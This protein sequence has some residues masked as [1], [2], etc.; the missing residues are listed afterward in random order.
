MSRCLLLGPLAAALGLVAPLSAA[1][2]LPKPAQKFFGQYCT[3][4]HGPKKQAGELRLD[5][6]TRVDAGSARQWT[7]VLERL[8]QGE[9]PPAEAL[10]PSVAEAQPI[11][12][13]LTKELERVETEGG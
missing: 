2:G 11:I 12:D 13:W 8:T 9:M 6:L 1:D 3:R 7:K 10:Q 5:E 4:C